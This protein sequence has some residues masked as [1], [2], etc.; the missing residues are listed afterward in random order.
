MGLRKNLTDLTKE[1][2][3][4]PKGQY[5]R[6]LHKLLEVGLSSGVTTKEIKAY[7]DTWAEEK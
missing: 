2:Q 1:Y 5:F 6:H 7:V 4:D 3:K